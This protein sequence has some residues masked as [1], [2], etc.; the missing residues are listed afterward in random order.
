MR[1]SKVDKTGEKVAKEK[2][3]LESLFQKK[4]EIESDIEKTKE[5]ITKLEQQWRQEKLEAIASLAGKNGISIDNLLEAVTT[6]DFFSIMEK[7][8]SN[9]AEPIAEDNEEEIT[10]PDV[11]DVEVPESAF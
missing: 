5:E 6:N 8:E 7:V 3:K 2:A 9:G 10:D 4:D 1:K 11:D